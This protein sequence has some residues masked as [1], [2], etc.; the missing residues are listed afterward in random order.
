MRLK[1]R[2][3]IAL[4]AVLL[5][6]LAPSQEIS[7]HEF[8]SKVEYSY[9]AAKAPAPF[10]AESAGSRYSA[11]PE[12]RFWSPEMEARILEEI[13]KERSEGLVVRGTEVEC[14]SSTCTVVLVHAT[15]NGSEGSVDDLTDKLR[16][17]LGFQSVSTAEAQ[18]PLQLQV[19]TD[20]G[21]RVTTTFVQGYVEIVLI[22]G[23]NANVQAREVAD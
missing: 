4:A 16:E 20:E 2:T 23:I 13:E 22:G 7:L 6:G 17:G 18:I 21:P 5:P 3:A 8:F 1:M 12:D 11:E 9:P 19:D 14:R 15:S 10:S